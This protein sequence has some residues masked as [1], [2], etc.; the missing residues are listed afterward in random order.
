[1]LFVSLLEPFKGLVGV[2]AKGV[3]SRDLE[4]DVVAMAGDERVAG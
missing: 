4:R 3:N 1:L 2:A